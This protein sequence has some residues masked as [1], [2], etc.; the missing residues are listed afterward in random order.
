MKYLIYIL[1]FI[2]VGFVTKAQFPTGVPT[3]KINGWIQNWYTVPDSGTVIPKRD[4][5]WT[6]SKPGMSITWQHGG[7]DTSVFFWNGAKWN[8]LALQ[9]GVPTNTNIANAA[10]TWNANYVQ[11]VNNFNLRFDS[12][13][14]FQA[15]SRGTLSSRKRISNFFMDANSLTSPLFLRHDISKV[16]SSTLGDSINLILQVLADQWE[17]IAKNTTANNREAKLT[18]NQSGN[19]GLTTTAGN[20][21]NSRSISL[22]TISIKIRGAISAANADSIY[23]AG[24]F[25]PVT[26]SNPVYLI[27]KP[28]TGTGTVTSV[29]LSMPSAFSISGSPITTSGT[30]SVTGAGTTLQ[31]IRGNGTLATFDT[32]AIPSFSAKVR[33]LFSGT[34]PITYNQATGAF[35]ISNATNVS[36]GAASFNASNFTVSSGAVSLADVVSAG[37]CT[38]CDLNINDK[39]QITGFS[40][41]SGGGGVDSLNAY[42]Y[43]G[44]VNSVRDTF[45]NLH[46]SVYNVK[47]FGLVDDSA[48]DNTTDFRALLALVPDGARIYFPGG[49]VGYLFNDTILINKNLVIY[50][51]GKSAYPIFTIINLPHRGATNL[52]FNSSTKNF[53]HLRST[54]TNKNPIVNIRDLSIINSSA[55]QPTAGSGIMV[56]DNTMHQWFDNITVS[57]FYNN[58]E[59][60]GS[61]NL[62]VSNSN[63]VSPILNGI[64]CGNEIEPDG[65]GVRIINNNIVSGLHATSIARGVYMKGGGAIIISQNFFNAQGTLD[66]ASQFVYD[67]YSDFADG[68][69]SEININD[70]GFANYKTTAIYIGNVNLSMRVLKINQNYITPLDGSLTH[71]AIY[72]ENFDNVQVGDISAYGHASSTSTYPVVK[73]FNVSNATIGPIVQTDYLTDYTASSSSGISSV[74]ENKDNQIKEDASFISVSRNFQVWKDASPSKAVA[75]GMNNPGDAIGNDLVFSNYNGSSWVEFGRFISS[76]NHLRIISGI[77]FPSA[78]GTNRNITISNNDPFAIDGLGTITLYP[79]TGTNASPLLGLVPR[80]SGLFANFKSQFN[81]Y[82]TDAVADPTNTESLVFSAQGDSLSVKTQAG[83]TGTVRPLKLWTGANT[84]QVSLNTDG[85]VSMSNLAGS[86]TRMV[87]VTSLG[88]FGTSTIGNTLYSGDGSIAS[89]RTVTLG[90]NNLTFDASS[91]GDIAFTLGSDATG[92]IFYRNSGGVLTRRAIGSTNDVLTVS[93][94]LPVWQAPD[95]ASGTY[96]PTLTNVTNISASTAYQCQYMRVGNVVTVSGKVDIDPTVAGAIRLGISLPLSSAVPNDFECAGVA[97]TISGA[98]IYSGG[99]RADT[100]NDRADLNTLILVGDVGNESYFFTFTYL[101]DIS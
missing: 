16:G 91:S 34:S 41:G 85:T 69:T 68:R 65:G 97:S 21:V 25:D 4:T 60:I 83:G 40:D 14:I 33:S 39:G 78:S 57:G 82:N 30:F 66:T 3:Q 27:P 76:T 92:D 47:D 100:V 70:N 62:T 6:P 10:L 79:T 99:I 58:I 72:I 53:L 74:V 43:A 23:A 88:V 86:G 24:A 48:T 5:S 1:L 32:A 75:V 35:G 77:D 94:G 37:S 28:T 11:N 63:I 67:I 55:T 98:V 15:I 9:S 93:G 17:L 90:S 89:A 38:S 73:L 29:A 87:T 31:Y 36:K 84:G 50:G 71:E 95:Y 44:N 51:D 18:V 56:N 54:L 42:R 80:G 2:L 81:I 61:H 7:S 46:Y 101:I 64:V 59:I 13:D 20:P 49:G 12:I 22:D 96:T 26:Q 19:I 52:Y 8:K 45:Q